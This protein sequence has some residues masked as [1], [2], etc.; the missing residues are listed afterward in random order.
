MRQC[1]GRASR[2]IAADGT[3][4]E[5]NC[6]CGLIDKTEEGPRF[7]HRPADLTREEIAE[8]YPIIAF[9][10]FEH[11]PPRLQ[12]VSGPAADLAVKMARSLPPGPEVEAGLRKL[13]EA[14]DCFVRAALA[15]TA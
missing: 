9:F 6:V 8:G 7:P 15:L 4:T 13:L 5:W 3:A 10:R 2:T 11:L 14:K 1:Y 12:D